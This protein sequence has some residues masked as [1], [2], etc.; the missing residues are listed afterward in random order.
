MKTV[1]FQ[2]DSI[3]DAGRSREELTSL[4]GGYPSFAS[5][6]AE[7]SYPGEYRYINRGISGNR[8]VD[9]LARVKADIIN[10][11]PD[12]MSILIGVNDVWHELEKNNGVD[13]N[14][15]K[16]YYRLLLEQVR[17]ALPDT[18]LLIMEPFVL[19]G[20]NI[21][22]YYDKFRAEV[23]LRAASAKELAEEFE[24]PFL[25]LQNKLDELYTQKPMGY[26]LGD[27]VH[28]TAEGHEFIAREWMTEFKKF[29]DNDR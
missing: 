25:P 2:G 27:G 10:L 9:L 13:N 15:Y 18:K 24:I 4:G 19:K 6:L 26:W 29:A 8:S 1:L 5:G 20:E 12:F 14:R 21:L 17:E 7:K 28:P 16:L 11:K 3:T 22:K 23:E